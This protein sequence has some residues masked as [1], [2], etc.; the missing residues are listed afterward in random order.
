M[1][2]RRGLRTC[3]PA[4]GTPSHGLVDRHHEASVTVDSR[5]GG[6]KDPPAD[7]AAKGSSGYW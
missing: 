4:L 2:A 7:N 5:F 1:K 6:S 3:Q